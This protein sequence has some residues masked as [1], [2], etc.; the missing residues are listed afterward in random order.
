MK[1]TLFFGML[2]SSEFLVLGVV[3]LIVIGIIIYRFMKKTK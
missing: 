2:G 3:L 1:T